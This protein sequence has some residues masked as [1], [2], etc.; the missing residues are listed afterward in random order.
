[1]STLACL[2]GAA[3]TLRGAHG[4]FCSRGHAERAWLGKEV[5]R[6]AD[7]D[8][9]QHVHVDAVN[10]LSTSL[11]R[12]DMGRASWTAMH[13]LV[14]ALEDD[15]QTF[16][17]SKHDLQ[18]TRAYIGI[19]TRRYPCEM[20]RE[21]FAQM[22]ERSPPTFTTARGAQLWVA[23]RHNEVNRR[24]GKRVWPTDAAPASVGRECRR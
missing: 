13:A 20:C 19:L 15:D 17:L 2:C 16:A 11:S 12:E 5:P 6:S 4:V 7:D 1:M 10:L 3:A 9:P 8:E 14:G 24:L 23:E 21:H 22:V 18:D